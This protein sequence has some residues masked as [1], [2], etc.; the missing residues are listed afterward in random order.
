MNK[1]NKGNEGN[2][3]E[4]KARIEAMMRELET[5][6]SLAIKD[7]MFFLPDDLERFK[8]K[9][10]WVLYVKEGKIVRMDE[11]KEEKKE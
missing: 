11:K 2:K 5:S 7:A 9:G 10:N 1:E 4:E 6:G 8:G 3:D